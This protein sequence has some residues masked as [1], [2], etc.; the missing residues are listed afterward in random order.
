MQVGFKRRNGPWEVVEAVHVDVVA[1]SGSLGWNNR[2]VCK[3]RIRQ[4]PETFWGMDLTE[5]QI[6]L[7]EYGH[8]EIQGVELESSTEGY[9]E[10]ELTGARLTP[11]QPEDPEYWDLPL[12]E[13]DDEGEPE[14]SLVLE[15]ELDE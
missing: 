12:P 5:G 9:M 7:T 10:V 14:A 3:V 15:E 4:D 8:F 1:L 11:L 13:L 2:Q 6:Y